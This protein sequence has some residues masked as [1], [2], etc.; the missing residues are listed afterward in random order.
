M[1]YKAF[2]VVVTVQ[3]LIYIAQSIRSGQIPNFF[4][5]LIRGMLV[6]I[7]FGIAFD[8]IVGHTLGMFTYYLGFGLMFLIINGFFSYGFMLANVCLLQTFSLWHVYLW[9]IVVG[10]LYE[11]VNYH[12]PVWQWTFASEVW[13]EELVVIFG[14]YF[15]LTLG[16]MVTLRIVY[17]KRFRALP[18]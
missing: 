13:I 1:N 7:P 9:S 8:F 5:Y 14:A 17:G 6:G 4:P 2:A 12:F 11:I 10:T 3:L 16:M 15:G 18:F